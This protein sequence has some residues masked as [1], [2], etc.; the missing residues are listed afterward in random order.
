MMILGEAALDTR[1][2]IVA[3]GSWFHMDAGHCFRKA[4]LAG[5]LSVVKGSEGKSARCHIEE[6]AVAAAGS[7]T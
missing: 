6:V 2:E 4:A 3:V 1:T 7:L 5:C